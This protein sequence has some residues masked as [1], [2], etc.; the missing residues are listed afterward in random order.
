MLR[1]R[2]YGV[3]SE[4]VVK[5]TKVVAVVGASKN[6]EK[7]AFSVPLYLMENGFVIIPV[8]P[9]ADAIHGVKAFPSLAELPA[10]VASRIDVVEV[11]RPSD[12]L[13]DIARHVVA[14]KKRTGK[15]VVFWAQLGL[16]SVDAERIL[17]EGEVPYVMDACMRTQHQHYSLRK[18]AGSHRI[19]AAWHERNP[20]PKNPTEKE[21]VEWHLAHA[22][23]CGCRP[24]PASLSAELASL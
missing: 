19:N 17:K 15:T 14:M 21:R 13:P 7:D 5:G 6:L 9:S 2:S 16:Q 8:N 20:M 23:E 18:P 12:E 10:G 3:S 1:M 24:A 11:F 4:E 22:K